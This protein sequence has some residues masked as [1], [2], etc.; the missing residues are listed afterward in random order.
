M[1]KE[2][3]DAELVERF[4]AYILNRPNIIEPK[5]PEELIQTFLQL[6]PED[7]G[8]LANLSPV[9]REEWAKRM[10]S[11]SVLSEE[12]NEELM[13]D[14]FCKVHPFPSDDETGELAHQEHF[15]RLLDE[16]K[17]QLQEEG[18]LPWQN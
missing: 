10:R 11:P 14:Y 8:P 7:R 16:A 13:F 3:N 15:D 4:K 17:H 12:C 2:E 5:Y 1:T 9:E 18:K 6:P